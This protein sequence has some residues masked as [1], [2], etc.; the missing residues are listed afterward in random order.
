MIHDVEGPLAGV[1]L[2]LDDV[3]GLQALPCDG[4]GHPLEDAVACVHV[5]CSLPSPQREE[6]LGWLGS[7]VRR[8]QFVMA[9]LIDR[10]DLYQIALK[11]GKRGVETEA[12]AAKL[13]ALLQDPA[14]RESRDVPDRRGR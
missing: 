6:M 12:A 7:L 4:I 10:R 1:A 13:E 11:P 5:K 3:D 2:A 14:A 9:A 8:A